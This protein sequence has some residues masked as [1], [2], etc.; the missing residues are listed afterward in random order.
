MKAIQTLIGIILIGLSTFAQRKKEKLVKERLAAHASWQ[1]QIVHQKK[2]KKIPFLLAFGTGIA[3]PFWLERTE[4]GNARLSRIYV[5]TGL[6]APRAI[7]VEH[8][9]FESVPAWQF[10]IAFKW[11]ERL[12]DACWIKCRVGQNEGLRKKAFK[13]SGLK[14]QALGLGGIEKEPLR[15]QLSSLGKQRT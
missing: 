15:V 7:F 3:F 4:E 6:Y 2:E 12:Q 14:L 10:R 1:K 8:L 9:E 5:E 13:D 11:L